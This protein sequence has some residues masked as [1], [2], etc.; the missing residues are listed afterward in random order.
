MVDG[1]VLDVDDVAIDDGGAGIGAADSCGCD[2]AAGCCGLALEENTLLK[3]EPTLET[4]LLIDDPMLDSV[5]D[6][7]GAGAA[8]A[9][10]GTCPA[11]G[12]LTIDAFG[13]EVFAEGVPDA[14]DNAAMGAGGSPV[15]VVQADV[16]VPSD[17][18]DGVAAGVGIDE[19]DAVLCTTPP[20]LIPCGTSVPRPASL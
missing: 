14:G 7:A 9:A 12:T 2:A 5:D 4:P 19:A 1:A 3:N 10:G 20:G 8:E 11:P 16:A 13:A 6:P 17:V 18:A 15:D